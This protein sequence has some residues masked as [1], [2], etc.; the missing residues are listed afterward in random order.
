M[1]L[2][3]NLAV[4][5]TYTSPGLQRAQAASRYQV[6]TEEDREDVRQDIPAPS[7]MSATVFRQPCLRLYPRPQAILGGIQL[8]GKEWKSL[9][10]PNMEALGLFRHAS[11]ISQGMACRISCLR[12]AHQLN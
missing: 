5:L 12:Y 4:P 8:N 10:Q 2:S 9:G 1:S 7:G 6:P 3:A 11:R